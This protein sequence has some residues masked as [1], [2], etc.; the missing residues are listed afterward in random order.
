MCDNNHLDN[1]EIALI[2][3]GLIGSICEKHI[4]AEM[5]N[6]VLYQALG[7]TIHLAEHLDD[8]LEDKDYLLD[9]LK[10]TQIAMGENV[11]ETEKQMEQVKKI[12]DEVKQNLTGN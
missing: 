11:A 7:L 6:P 10:T 12:I 8:N 5:G 3:I 1:Q 9:L 4:E 2:A